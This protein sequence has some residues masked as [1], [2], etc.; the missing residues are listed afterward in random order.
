M[1]LKDRTD[2]SSDTKFSNIYSQF[3]TLLDA[4]AKINLDPLIIKSINQD[5]EE[6][7]QST[8]AGN[9][10]RKLVKDKQTKILKHLEKEAQIVPQNYYRNLWLPLGMAAFGLPFG[11][12]IGLSMG[13]MGLLAI[14]L[15]FGMTIGIII[16][17]NLDKKAFAEGRQLAIDIKHKFKH[18]FN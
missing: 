10:L 5:V 12:A 4:L 16:G 1:K 7:N 17:L 11:T 8:F 15:P 13:N 18:F 6:L 9:E 3:G 2:N 14:G